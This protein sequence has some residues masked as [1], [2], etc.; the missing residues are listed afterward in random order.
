A[1]VDDQVK[2]HGHRVELG[3]VETCL[4]RL[5]GVGAA[6]AVIHPDERGSGQLYGYVV[7]E[8]E[9]VSL[10]LAALRDELA[11]A[12]PAQLVPRDLV[13]M[14]ALPLTL[15]GKVDRGRLPRPEAVTGGSGRAAQN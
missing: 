5:A 12:V 14:D 7:P 6:A 8:T 15:N 13:R 11:A 3:E 10:D 4:G 9:G 2:V 1:R